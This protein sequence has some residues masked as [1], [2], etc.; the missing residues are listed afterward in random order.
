M[1]ILLVH[2]S[3]QRP[4][5]E[6][7]AFEQERR[8]LVEHGH[9]VVTYR[10]SNLELDSYS[11][12]QRLVLVK[13]VVWAADT[14]REFSKLL[15]Q[16][17]PHLVHIHNTF[18]MASPSVYSACREARVPVVQT[19]HNYRLLCPAATL[20]RDGR[21]CTECMDHSLWGGIRHGCYRQSRATTAAVAFMLKTHRR[22]RTWVELV[23]T[24]IA[25][26]GFAR[27]LFIRGGLPA[28]KIFVKPNFV[29]PD[30]GA[31]RFEGEYAL[32]VGRL[33][34]EKGIQLLVKAW[35]RLGEQIPLRI[36]GDGPLR[37]DL[38]SQVA[39]SRL[40]TI[41]FAGHLER[42]QVLA[43]MKRARFVIVPSQCYENFPATICEAF[44]CGAPVICSQLGAMKE[45]VKPRIGQYFDPGDAQDLANKVK[46]AWNHP[47]EMALMGQEARKEYATKYT[48]ERNYEMLIDIYQRTLAGAGIAIP[49]GDPG[50]EHSEQLEAFT[51]TS[52]RTE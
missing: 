14:R 25:L 45:L 24:Y 19:L 27:D 50:H 21:V 15:L 51:F 33:S 29:Y 32:F 48:P 10:R 4:G 12:L 11:P 35:E 26:T 28:T 9:H 18:V 16:E 36:I 31:Q 5:G 37:A 44:S 22:K 40:S 7:V 42:Q 23:N 41:H 8:L 3:Y 47:E 30:P 2:N 1:K 46:W 17:K 20:F 6:D 49:D 38:E 43:A 39:A 52:A 13:D 34:P